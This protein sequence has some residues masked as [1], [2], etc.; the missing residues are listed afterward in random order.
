MNPV[1][2]KAVI[3]VGTIIDGMSVIGPFE[4]AASA[5]EYAGMHL[6]DLWMVAAMYPP[7]EE[8]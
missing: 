1:Q 6:G 5:V 8:K 4:S 7:Q 3:L 2:C